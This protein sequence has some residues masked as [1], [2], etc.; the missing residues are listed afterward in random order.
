MKSKI[1]I[2]L[3]F[4][5]I[6]FGSFNIFFNENCKAEGNEIYVDV[7][8]HGIR[9]GSPEK[10]YNSIQDAINLAEEGDTIYVFGGLYDENGK[11]SWLCAHPHS[12]YQQNG[13]VQDFRTLG[14]L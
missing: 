3:I 9:D 14:F 6:I 8:Y 10:P 7:N 13:T 5:S 4:F 12:S 1:V 2:M 11:R